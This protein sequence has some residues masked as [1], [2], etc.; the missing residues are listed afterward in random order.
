MSISD[1]H[2]VVTLKEELEHV[3]NYLLI[4]QIRYHNSF[5]YDLQFDENTLDK[6]VLKLSIQPLVENAI[7]HGINREEYKHILIKSYLK[8][9]FI[10]LEVTNEGYGI[11]Q[12]RIAEIYKMMKH[13]EST[14][15]V[16]LKNIYERLQLYYGKQADVIIE[17]EMDVE[18][19]VTL[20]MP[21]IERIEE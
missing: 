4:Q 18:T 20:K 19:K 17:S 6:Y 21:I 16:G 9:G 1:E 11:S 5:A 15:S 13:K 12:E 8:D 14:K 10:Y 2:S 7:I 3:T